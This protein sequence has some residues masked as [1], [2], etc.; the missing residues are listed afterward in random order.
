M[1]FPLTLLANSYVSLSYLNVR[2]QEGSIDD[3]VETFGNSGSGFGLSYGHLFRSYAPEISYK[4]Y[5][6]DGNSDELSVTNKYLNLGFRLF[7][8]FFNLKLGFAIDNSIGETQG[9]AIDYKSTN[10]TLS[11]GLGLRHNFEYLGEKWDVF[12]DLNIHSIEDTDDPQSKFIMRELE[13]G[14]RYYF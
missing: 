8:G 4:V 3:N 5:R 9:G 7:L 1:L 11:Y 14:V 12:G 6:I 10:T 2:V 13:F